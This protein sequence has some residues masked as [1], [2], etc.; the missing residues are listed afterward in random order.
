VVHVDVELPEQMR[1]LV[2]AQLVVAVLVGLAPGLA[3]EQLNLVGL[4]GLLHVVADG[5]GPQLVLRLVGRDEIQRLVLAAV[6]H[7]EREG[8]CGGTGPGLEP[9]RDETEHKKKKLITTNKKINK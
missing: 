9:V 6:D 7:R 2:Q 8:L 3:Q 1:D 4:G 5:I